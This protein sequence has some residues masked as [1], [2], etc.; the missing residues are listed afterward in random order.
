MDNWIRIKDGKLYDYLKRYSELE[1]K[2]IVLDDLKTNGEKIEKMLNRK[3]NQFFFIGNNNN[4]DSEE[5][6]KYIKEVQKY[7]DI[8][9]DN[10]YTDCLVH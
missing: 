3:I 4:S 1:K 10:D 7:L 2:R 5:Y 6:A 8:Y 9:K